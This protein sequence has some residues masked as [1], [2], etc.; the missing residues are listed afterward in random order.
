M[1]FIIE[2]LEPELFEWCMIEY[3]HISKIIGKNNLIFTNINDKKNTLKLKKLGTVYD[4][5]ISQL[6]NKLKFN[7][8]VICV[9]SQYSK[10]TLTKVDKDKFGCFVFGG[11]LGDNPAKKR[12]K[13]L[14]NRLKNQGINF[15]TRNLGNVQMPTDNAV[16]AAKKILEGK[17]FDEFKFID[18][19]E[20]E[21]NEN[22]SVTL[23]FRY[24]VDNNKL[25]ISEKLVE[26]LRKRKE[27]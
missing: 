21:I 23:P 27:F 18:E 15:E 3:G 26:Y 13:R 25:V 5:N 10:K 19:V 17:K 14:T 16:F 8:L 9:L 1:N 2:H 24:I 6:N 22:E 12:T 4:K 20:I 11:I 7:N